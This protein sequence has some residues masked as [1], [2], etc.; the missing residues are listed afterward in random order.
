MNI[1][2][3][4]DEIKKT[5]QIYIKKDADGHYI[6][7][8]A[9]QRPVLLIGPPGI[10]KTAIMQQIANEC[11]IGIVSYTITHHTRQSAVGL[12]VILQKNFQGK[13]YSITQYTMSEIIASVYSKI[14]ETSCSEGIL[15]IDEIN[16]VSETLVPTM[17]QFLQ[18]KTFGTHQVPDGWI[19]V[20]AGNPVEYNRSARE[21]DIVTLDRVKKINIEPDFEIWKEYAYSR[22]LH[23][24]II[25]F[26]NIHNDYFYHIENNASGVSFATARGWDDLSSILLAYEKMGYAPNESLVL[27]YIQ[28]E[29]I[30]RA[31]F[32]YY[33]LYNQYQHDYNVISILDGSI[34]KESYAE[35]LSTA[36]HADPDERL[37]VTELIVD[38]LSSSFKNFDANDKFV[39]SLQETFRHA[40]L[41]VSQGTSFEDFITQYRLSNEFHVTYEFKTS[42]EALTPKIT[43]AL[44]SCLAKVKSGRIS[45]ADEITQILQEKLDFT[46]SGRKKAAEQAKLALQ[47]AFNFIKEAFGEN[48]PEILYLVSDLSHN[49]LAISYISQFG[50]NEYLHYSDKLKFQE[51]R[52]SLLNEIKNLIN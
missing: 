44:E 52:L 5:V 32:A 4:K 33:I 12:P 21:F 1:K 15:F 35:I 29:D 20:A 47:R 45:S 3:A 24:G 18:N 8:L 36:A 42:A 41:A 48:G 19:I 22:C 7:P 11:G 50:C 25:S 31:F 13:E 46:S 6:I 49:P 34:D 23:P 28:D 26:L 40:K 10:G 9:K 27:Q 30:A 2:D 38:G 37:A 43:A 16:C 51:E 14:E 39:R 17:L